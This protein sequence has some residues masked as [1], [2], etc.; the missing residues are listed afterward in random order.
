MQSLIATFFEARN[1][2]IEKLCFVFPNFRG[3]VTGAIRKVQGAACV[4]K[5]RKVATAGLHHLVSL[6]KSTNVDETAPA[7][8]REQNVVPLIDSVSLHYQLE[9]DGKQVTVISKNG[10]FLVEGCCYYGVMR[11]IFAVRGSMC[12]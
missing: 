1:P 12:P 5:S 10:E 7:A 2:E 11:Q 4:S 8:V 6:T 3:E 9:A